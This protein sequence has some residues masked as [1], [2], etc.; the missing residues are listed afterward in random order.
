M[1]ALQWCHF[2]G[3]YF[4]QLNYEPR[5]VSSSYEIISGALENFLLASKIYVK[6]NPVICFFVLQTAAKL[7]Q[8][9]FS[10]FVANKKRYMDIKEQEKM[11][12]KL[13]EVKETIEIED[14]ND[15][16]KNGLLFYLSI[17]KAA[18]VYAP[19]NSTQ[20]QELLATFIGQLIR[21]GVTMSL[22]AEIFSTMAQGI[23]FL[24]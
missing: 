22:N 12:Q 23:K 2:M 7:S 5:Y 11:F 9:I 15:C 20:G 1:K 4:Q 18:F 3:K 17:D 6:S 16:W 14:Q 10:Y 19:T 24:Y 8:V 13:D 21:C